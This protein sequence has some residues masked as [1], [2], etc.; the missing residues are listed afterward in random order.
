[1]CGCVSNR[2]VRVDVCPT[3]A[4]REGENFLVIDPIACVDCDLCSAECPVEAIFEED[5][6]PDDQIHFTELN[7]E[8]AKQWPVIDEATEPMPNYQKWDGMANKLALLKR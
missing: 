2:C 7:A 1:L 6:V 5:D 3:D 8:L 4:S